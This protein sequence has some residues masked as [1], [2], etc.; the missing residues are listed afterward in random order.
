MIPVYSCCTVAFGAS[1]LS[2]LGW[3]VRAF[4]V[5]KVNPSRSL[6]VLPALVSLVD[7]SKNRAG[8]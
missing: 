1:Q 7:Q 6:S 5:Q 8:K 3:L 4:G 2:T